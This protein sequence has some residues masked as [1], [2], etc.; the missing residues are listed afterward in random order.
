MSKRK[1]VTRMAARS[2]STSQYDSVV[3]IMSI[4][5]LSGPRRHGHVHLDG[6]RILLMVDQSMR[7]QFT[8]LLISV[9]LAISCAIASTSCCYQHRSKRVSWSD[10]QAHCQL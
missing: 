2:P 8:S 10:K 7:W 6:L 4:L 9:K 3:I 5:Q 1:R